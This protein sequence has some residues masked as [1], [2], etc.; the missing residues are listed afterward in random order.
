ME[1]RVD[2]GHPPPQILKFKDVTPI[3]IMIARPHIKW[4]HISMEINRPRPLVSARLVLAEKSGLMKE[5][6]VQIFRL[7]E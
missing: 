2:I 6:Q 1:E 4:S 5:A 7:N 3:D